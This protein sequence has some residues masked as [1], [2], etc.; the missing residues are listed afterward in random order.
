MN[1]QERSELEQ[2]E[3][4]LDIELDLD[5]IMREFAAEE[6]HQIQETSAQ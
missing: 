2:N 1:E 6:G 5:D 4:E 3:Q